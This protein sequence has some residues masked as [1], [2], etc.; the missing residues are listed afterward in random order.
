MAQAPEN[1]S[2]SPSQLEELLGQLRLRLPG[3][4][5]QWVE[6]LLRTLQ[7]LLAILEEKKT[8]LARLRRLLFGPKSAKAD[9]LLNAGASTPASKSGEAG[10]KPKR[11]GHGR[12]AARDYPGA[13]RVPVRHPQFQAGDLCPQC[14]KAKLCLLKV[15]ARIIGLVA[16][17]IFQATLYQLDRL[18]CA[19]CGALFTAPAPPEAGP[20]KYDPSV[21]TMLAILR[22]GAGLPMY[23][24]EKWQHCFGV[25]LPA[26]TQWQ[27]IE[28]ASQTPELV[29]EA[30]IDAAANG[31]LL[32]NDDTPMRVQS[33]RSPSAADPG[34]AKPRTGIFTTGIISQI[35]EHRAALFF[36]GDHHAGENPDQVL[37]RRSTEPEPPLQMCDALSRNPAKQTPTQ[38]CHCLLHGRRNFVDLIGSFPGQCRKVIESL[39]EIYRLDAL[40]KG[41]HFSDLQRLHLHQEHSRPVMDGL[42]RW[43]TQQIDQKKVEPNSGLGQAIAYL[44]KHWEPLTRFLHVPGAPLD[45]NI[46]ERALKMAI[47]HRKNSLSY[48]TL[49][50][51]RVGDIFMSL[52]HTCQLNAINPYD[53]LMALQ[54]H[55]DAVRIDP[56]RRLPWN[57][58]ETL[59]PL[60]PLTDSG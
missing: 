40:A 19:T 30:L 52:I 15:P 22:Y 23:R 12:K 17:P 38:L 18:R 39:R 10:I 50:G 21:G 25:P 7:W 54:N 9:H 1:V 6:S 56:S 8:S 14:R 13:K 2:I 26:S 36:T 41:Q 5:C 31:R 47:L 43:M 44:L 51:A 32:H 48:K 24:I 37:K 46:C 34:A 11:P 55:A 59:A 29:Y 33:L 60:T 35:G 28:A 3:P 42:H 49:N 53:Y 58:Q 16:Q 45:N 4:T 27:L 57:Y 20:H